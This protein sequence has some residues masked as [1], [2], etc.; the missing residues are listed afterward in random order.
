MTYQ[1]HA[2]HDMSEKFEP[3]KATPNDLISP[4]ASHTPPPFNF[5]KQ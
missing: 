5:G 1:L 4:P 2:L 3:Y